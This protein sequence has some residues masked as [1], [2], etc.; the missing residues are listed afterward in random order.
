G[1][2]SLAY[3]ARRT[4]AL[5]TGLQVPPQAFIDALSTQ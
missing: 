1:L 5:W 4:L 2:T 3:Q